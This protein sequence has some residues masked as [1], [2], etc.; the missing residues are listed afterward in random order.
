MIDYE[1]QHRLDFG[2]LDF[3]GVEDYEGARFYAMADGATLGN[4]VPVERSIETALLDGSFVVTE[5]HGNREPAWQVWIEAPDSVALAYGEKL[6]FEQCARRVEMGWTP[7]DGW[8]P[9][10][11]YEAFTSS[12]THQFDDMLEMRLVRSYLLRVVAAPF[13]YSE[14]E[15]TDLAVEPAPVTPVTTT[16]AS[17]TSATGWTSPAG[18]VTSDGVSLLV[19]TGAPGASLDSYGT[20][21]YYYSTETTFTFTAVNFSATRYVSA[22]VSFRSG[23]QF[24][25]SS[26]P[27]IYTATID[28]AELSVVTSTYLG[29]G[30]TRLTWQCADS[31]ATTLRIRASFQ[32]TTTS[33]T[34]GFKIANLSRSNVAPSTP[35]ATGRQSLRIVSVTGSA[36]TAGSVAIGHPTQGLGDVLLYTSPELA[37]GYNPDVT[38]YRVLSGSSV[39]ADATTIAGQYITSGK[40][41]EVDA[42]SLPAGPYLIMFRASPDSGTGPREATVSVRSVVGGVEFAEQVLP[43]VSIPTGFSMGTYS[44]GVVTLPLTRFTDESVGSVQIEVDASSVRLDKV[45]AFYL[46]EDADLT[47]VKA[48]AGTPALG[49]VHSRLFLDAPT[50]ANDGA[51]G[52]F[53]GTQADRSDAFHPGYPTVQSWGRHL[54]APPSVNLFVVTTGAANP[55]VSLRHRP[56]WHTHAGQ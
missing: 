43:T 25:F 11:V 52:L 32:T 41:F 15:V 35:T 6:L 4:P 46:G 28:G 53:V 24:S 3:T 26:A 47:Y 31:S 16:M 17:G 21:V 12:L 7:P 42:A 30:V 10:T 8:G 38:P 5:S 1:S 33:G 51:P 44:A 56:A 36:R 29:S 13:G 50:L 39:T 49:T 20:T 23:S 48:G 18:T 9:R 34:F 2:G 19:P 40:V 54:F 14:D 37:R 45:W 55:S 27:Y 22:D